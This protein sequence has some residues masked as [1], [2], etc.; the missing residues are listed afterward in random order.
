MN[1]RLF[2]AVL[3]LAGILLCADSIA[4]QKLLLKGNAKL[5]KNVLILDGKGSYAEIPGT[6]NYNISPPGLTLACTVKLNKPAGKEY[7][8][9]FFSKPGTPFIFA[10]YNTRLASNLRN[11]QNKIT[12]KTR[13]NGI[14]Q[15]GIRHHLAVTYAFFNDAAQGERGYITTLYLDGEKLEQEIHP[16]FEAKQTSGN[17]EIGRGYSSPWFL[18]GEVADI[19][20]AQKVLSPDEINALAKKS[21]IPAKKKANKSYKGIKKIRLNEAELHL[22]TLDGKGSPIAGMVD[23]KGKRELLSG[24]GFSWQIRGNR[25]NQNVRFSSSE[26]PF[27]LQNLSSKGFSAVWKKSGNPAFEVVS[28]VTFVSDGFTANLEIRNKT[29]DFV[30]KEVLFPEV[31]IPAF[32][33][34]DVLFYPYMCGAEIPSPRRNRL[35]YGQNYS[36]PSAYVT[37]QYSAYY[38]NGRGVFLG[39]QDPDGTIKNLSAGG[40]SQTVNM[41]WTL[42]APIPLDK[43][44]GGNNFKTPGKVLFRLFKGSWYEAA[45]LHKDWALS[46]AVWG[47]VPLPRKDTPGWFKRVPCALAP[48]GT[49]E[50][51]ANEGVDLLLFLQKYM[52]QPIYA[53]WFN[54]YD[55][56]KRG[57]PAYPQHKYTKKLF[58]RI[59][60]S[61]CYIEPYTDGRLWDIKDTLWKKCGLP[62]SVKLA[63]G[64]VY[65]EKHGKGTY[66]VMCPVVNSWQQV[67]LDLS[68]DIASVSS[69][70]YH[71][72]VSA[73]RGGLCFDRTH[74]HALNDPAV[75][76]EGYRKIYRQI[77]KALPGYPQI[78][79]D[80]SEPYLDLFDGGHVW[81]WGF[82]GA[83]PAFQAVYGGRTQYFALVYDKIAKGDDE[84]NFAKMAYSLVN[85]IKIGRMEVQELFNA[86]EKRLF[87]KKMSH[88]YA[89]VCDYLNEGT[90]LAPIRFAVPVKTQSLMWSGHWRRNEKV[91]TPVIENRSYVLGQKRLYLFVNPTKKTQNC[92]PLISSGWLCREGAGKVEK[93]RGLIQ[94]PPRGSAVVI[95]D[96]KEALRIQK[97][98]DKMASFDA[99]LSYDTQIR[100]PERPPLVLKRGVLAGPEKTA[101]FYAVLRRGNNG[102]FF[103]DSKA[104]AIISWG[105]VDFGREKVDTIYLYPGVSK[106]FSGGKITVLTEENGKRVPI[107]SLT[108]Q[109]TGGWM[110]FKKLPVKLN[111]TL[112]GRKSIL[113]RYDRS[114]CCNL[115]GWS[116]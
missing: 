11:T 38:A 99:G 114:G 16:F 54:W 12:V 35:R 61:N 76:M 84:S 104:G 116:Y 83:V 111:K 19:F 18:N 21:Q 9:A 64:S 80:M 60:D 63:D 26:I 65:T 49:T 46:K 29:P 56:S 58:K 2:T 53:L 42:P 17:I 47:K 73:A 101:G 72:Q 43:I 87:F 75:W 74:G 20:A 115:L 51:S 70:V 98:L 15:T 27:T 45:M 4:P 67:L 103:G 37:M 3:L 100:F 8:A 44:S 77:R 79:E 36:Y 82:Q 69:A 110:K 106:E 88:L 40:Q 1:K 41:T 13:G 28:N 10:R 14:P 94:L 97:V 95:S 39:W 23:I 30:I 86:D 92:R 96:K 66:A 105:L 107:G 112:T 85:G 89:A 59:M 25:K 62:A 71:D 32:S 5:V 6:E 113:L 78:S 81:R 57:W 31:A 93:F 90:M 22:R 91:T 52:E 24:K 55:S 50:T 109:D 102:R 34:N 7:L 33:G 108:V 68:K 48:N